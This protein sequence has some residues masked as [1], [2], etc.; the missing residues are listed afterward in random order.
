MFRMLKSVALVT[1]VV[2][3][4][5]V[6]RQRNKFRK[7]LTETREELSSVK[8]QCVEQTA[9]AVRAEET[10]NRAL[11]RPTMEEAQSDSPDWD[12]N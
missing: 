7:E 3:F 8:I 10:L 5:A 6:R 9:R 1:V 12:T 4:V 2:G 11:E